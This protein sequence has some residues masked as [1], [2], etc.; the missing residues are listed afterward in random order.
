MRYEKPEIT[1]LASAMSAIQHHC[2]KGANSS[3]NCQTGDD[4]ATATAYEA[5]E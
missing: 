3:D 4:Q 1:F 5:D 2:D